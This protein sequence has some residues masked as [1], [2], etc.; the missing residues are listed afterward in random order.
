MAKRIA[1][2]VLTGVAIMAL[3]SLAIGLPDP[4]TVAGLPIMMAAIL[5][6]C[7]LRVRGLIAS[8]PNLLRVAGALIA[9]V[10]LAAP[11][12]TAGWPKF[13]GPLALAGLALG[14]GLFLLP[15]W[16]ALVGHSFG[17]AV[18]IRDAG[19]L[20]A[21]DGR[22][23]GWRDGPA[24]YRDVIA[25]W[26]DWL[27]IA[28]PW[29]LL[30][31]LAIVAAEA[32]IRT[33]PTIGLLK[34]LLA[35]LLPVLLLAVATVLAGWLRLELQGRRPRPIALPDGVAL[36]CLWRLALLCMAVTG[37]RGVAHAIA[38]HWNLAG[39]RIGPI[40]AIDI[41]ATALTLFMAAVLGSYLLGIVPSVTRD[42]R[43]GMM[44]AA[45]LHARRLK[46]YGWGLAIAA[47][48]FWLTA[49]ALAVV[50]GYG[51]I[52]WS[53]PAEAVV[54]LIGCAV[55][56]FWVCV[57]ASYLARAYRQAAQTLPGDPPPGLL[58]AAPVA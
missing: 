43:F 35:V 8:H 3:L 41:L 56:G 38:E 17:A 32:A 50:P 20:R 39:V 30:M 58:T 16:A 18:A 1:I 13:G 28:G 19:G 54:W 25:H 7:W 23:D 52:I 10:C 44:M 24:A 57:T 49:W 11:H 26:R 45:L 14:L 27:R 31:W 42:R 47:G 53:G 46:A 33:W 34:A 22:F 12:L 5:A 55:L 40:A 36:S 37:T 29:V 6:P 4:A 51:W 21:A 2:Y 48:P 15:W 9:G